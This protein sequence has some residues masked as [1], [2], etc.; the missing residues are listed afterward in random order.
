MVKDILEVTDDAGALAVCQA[1][2]Y[3]IPL[4]RTD[5]DDIDRRYEARKAALPG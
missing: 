3:E 4:Y 2:T 1:V 5:T